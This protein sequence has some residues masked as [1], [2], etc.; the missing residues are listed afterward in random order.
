LGA[1]PYGCAGVALF[2]PTSLDL[3]QLVDKCISLIRHSSQINRFTE[4]TIIAILA[5]RY[6]SYL[7]LKSISMDTLQTGFLPSFKCTGWTGRHYPGGWRSQFWID[8]FW[9]LLQ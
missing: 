6:G 7:K 9:R 5:R 1:P 4:Q 2:N 3:L 8:A